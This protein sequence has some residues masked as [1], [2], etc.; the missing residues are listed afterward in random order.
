MSNSYRSVYFDEKGNAQ[1]SSTAENSSLDEDL[2]TQFKN[3]N[4]LLEKIEDIEVQTSVRGKISMAMHLADDGKENDALQTLTDASMISV[5]AIKK[6]SSIKRTARNRFRNRAIVIGFALGMF[7]LIA[8]LNYFFGQTGEG[9]SVYVLHVLGLPLP[10]IM[11]SF[12]GGVA[13]TLYAFVGTQGQLEDDVFRVDWLVGRPIIG[14]I[15]GCVVYLALATSLSA[16]GT[17]V[18]DPTNPG[19]SPYLLYAIAFIGGF[20]DKF[21]ILL[22]ENLVGKFTTSNSKPVDEQARPAVAEGKSNETSVEE[23]PA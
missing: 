22:F 8:L 9:E 7:L 19:Q 20:S 11:W 3:I 23:N 12:I 6:E 13:A 2:K 10:I 16:V 4:N 17:E 21:A 18:I 1:I 14:V 15:M 5:K